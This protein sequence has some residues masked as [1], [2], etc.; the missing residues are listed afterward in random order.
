[1]LTNIKACGKT[2][3][4]KTQISYYITFVLL[5]KLFL[6]LFLPPPIVPSPRS[7]LA[8]LLSTEDL[9]SPVHPS[10]LQATRTNEGNGDGVFGETKLRLVQ[11]RSRPPLD[12]CCRCAH[13]CAAVKPA[14]QS[15]S[16]RPS[17]AFPYSIT[18]ISQWQIAASKERTAS[19]ASP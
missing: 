2:K 18:A 16:P 19:V 13:G 12:R 8:N 1:M 17:A 15:A 3:R 4:G 10:C 9:A 5:L 7:G 6:Y 11:Q 14:S